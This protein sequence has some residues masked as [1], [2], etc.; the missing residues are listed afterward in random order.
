L[1]D[2]TPWAISFLE[3]NKDLNITPIMSN[4]N[5]SQ[6]EVIP[7]FNLVDTLPH[8]PRK[9]VILVVDD[10]ARIR[11]WLGVALPQNGFQV[12]LAAGGQEAVDIYRNHNNIALVLLDVLM[13]GMD[14]PRTL[15]ALQTVNSEVCCCFL[16]E[17]NVY[18][19]AELLALG[20]SRVF[21]KM[22]KLPELVQSLWM[23]V[24]NVDE[25]ELSLQTTP[26]PAPEF[27]GEERRAC[28]R[29]LCHLDGT[30]QPVGH[31]STGESWLGKLRDISATG[32]KILINRRFEVGTLL[33][34]ELPRPGWE[35]TNM[36][37]CRVVRITK[38]PVGHDWEVGC[39]LDRELSDDEVQSYLDSSS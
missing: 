13:P 3:Q 20:A 19:P 26:G 11:A 17:R 39:A 25:S 27:R 28:V 21:V 12:K 31:P 30:C 7:K 10:E 22:P 4:T 1:A 38:D 9:P 2:F 29:Y 36:L 37:L 24:A 32:V 35:A 6:P 18:S 14:G 5:P 34:V 15:Q 33:A 8:V 23:L 16:N